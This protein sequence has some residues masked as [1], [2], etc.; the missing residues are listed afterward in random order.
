MISKFWTVVA[1][2]ALAAAVQAGAAP[3][4]VNVQQLGNKLNEVIARGSAQNR[5]SLVECRDSFANTCTYK[6]GAAIITASA[7]RENYTRLDKV[8]IQI[9]QSD[10]T[11]IL[12]F[13]Q[14]CLAVVGLF[15]PEKSSADAAAM[16]SKLVSDAAS[17]QQASTWNENMYYTVSS[18][19]SAIEF[20]VLPK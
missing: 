4:D 11:A 19:S 6:I 12:D 14:A 10:P 18:F 17:N 1:A 5:V 3:F 2:L 13:M 16:I 20:R 7:P 15:T 9:R 8:V